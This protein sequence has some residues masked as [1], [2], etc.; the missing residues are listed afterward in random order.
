MY[1]SG[2]DEPLQYFCGSLFFGALCVDFIGCAV[3]GFPSSE[4]VAVFKML[5]EAY[6]EWIPSKCLD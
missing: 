6:Y 5:Y 2:P 3:D 1:W 4:G